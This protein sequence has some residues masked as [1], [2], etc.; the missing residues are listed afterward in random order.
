MSK[1]HFNF[2][3]NLQ[4]IQDKSLFALVWSHKCSQLAFTSFAFSGKKN[5]GLS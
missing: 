5:V 2:E 3:F 1:L 4:A